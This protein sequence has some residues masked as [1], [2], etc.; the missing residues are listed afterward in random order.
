MKGQTGMAELP[1]GVPSPDKIV[2]PSLPEVRRASG[3]SR[4]FAP[5]LDEKNSPPYSPAVIFVC[6]PSSSCR[7][8]LS[9]AVK[10][11]PLKGGVCV[12]QTTGNQAGEAT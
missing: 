10:Q 3:R 12:L 2:L 7:I 6:D 1:G 4:L 11:E 5:H 9:L 8:F